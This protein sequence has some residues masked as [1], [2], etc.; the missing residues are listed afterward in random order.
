MNPRSFLGLGPNGF[1]RI[2]YVEW[3]EGRD[4]CVICVHG[5]TRNGRDFDR[6]AAALAG[7]RRVVCPDIVGRGQSD[8]PGWASRRSIGW[9]RRW[10]G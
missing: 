7:T 4:G 3:G 2:A 9:A 5:L 6:L 10:A 8:S 1:H